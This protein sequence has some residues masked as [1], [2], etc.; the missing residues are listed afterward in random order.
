MRVVSVAD[1]NIAGSASVEN[2]NSTTTMEA[3]LVVTGSSGNS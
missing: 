1:I 2:A 3:D